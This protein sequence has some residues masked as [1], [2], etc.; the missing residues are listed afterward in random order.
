MHTLQVSCMATQGVRVGPQERRAEASDDG[1]ILCAWHEGFATKHTV[2]L[3]L[4]A[5]LRLRAAYVTAQPLQRLR[6]VEL[7]LCERTV[8]IPRATLLL[9]PLPVVVSIPRRR[10]VPFH[11]QSTLLR[12]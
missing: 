9:R 4:A 2:A 6:F 5:E 12:S 8:W 1:E 3:A 7:P 11:T 10:L